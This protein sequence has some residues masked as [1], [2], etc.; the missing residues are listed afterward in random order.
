MLPARAGAVR[1]A[2]RV[3]RAF[4]FLLRRGALALNG[5]RYK[6]CEL[7]SYRKLVERGNGQDMNTTVTKLSNMT[8]CYDVSLRATA[9]RSMR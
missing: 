1:E 9:R 4:L 3:R 8:G 7:P 2:R 5:A 6:M